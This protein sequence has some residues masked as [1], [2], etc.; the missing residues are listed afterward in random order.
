MSSKNEKVDFLL[1]IMKARVTASQAVVCDEAPAGPMPCSGCYA[2][3]E[4]QEQPP[5]PSS[6]LTSHLSSLSSA[7]K[8]RVII[9]G[10]D[11]YGNPI[12]RKDQTITGKV[13]DHDLPTDPFCGDC[14]NTYTYDAEVR[15]EPPKLSLLK[16]YPTSVSKDRKIITGFDFYGNPIACK[17]QM[18]ASQLDD[19]EPL[20]DTVCGGCEVEAAYLAELQEQ[21]PKPSLQLNSYS[22]FPSSVKKERMI[23]KGFDFYGNPIFKAAVQQPT[24][25]LRNGEKERFLLPQ[26]DN[27]SE[28]LETDP[29]SSPDDLDI[30]PSCVAEFGSCMGSSLIELWRS[31]LAG[32]ESSSD[33]RAI[34]KALSEEIRGLR[35]SSKSREV[36]ELMLEIKLRNELAALR[37]ETTEMEELYAREMAHEISQKARL[38]AQLHL[39]LMQMTEDR[40]R[41]ETHLGELNSLPSSSINRDSGSQSKTNEDI[42]PT[43]KCTVMNEPTSDEVK[44]SL[45]ETPGG[46]KVTWRPSIPKVNVLTNPS[47]EK[48][49]MINNPVDTEGFLSPTMFRTPKEPPMTTDPEG[50]SQTGKYANR[51]VYYRDELVQTS[52]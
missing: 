47:F 16:S 8:E 19:Q 3:A 48:S 39:Q 21:L 4:N 50:S 46:E 13:M 32:E 17:D 45:S 43:A 20:A 12:T 30:N 22:C 15:E 7:P 1:E 6:Q 42:I 49:I 41:V 36:D 40:M 35:K 10:F 34:I 38:Q 18:A 24:S 5:K 2:P 25:N 31:S 14:E 52:E 27:Y 9:K 26:K 33:D 44:P 28:F 11:F 29:S 23:I 51:F 37:R